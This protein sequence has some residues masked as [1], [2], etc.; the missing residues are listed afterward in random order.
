MD[1]KT[2]LQ[3]LPP[4]LTVVYSKPAIVVLAHVV[5]R[6]TTLCGIKLPADGYTLYRPLGIG[7]VCGNCGDRFRNI[8]WLPPN[9]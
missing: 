9:L 8:D 1:I 4:P 5:E 3:R 2:L 7:G 6:D